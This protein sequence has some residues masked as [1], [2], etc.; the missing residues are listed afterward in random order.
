MSRMRTERC[1][2]SASWSLKRRRKKFFRALR[3]QIATSRLCTPPSAV[4]CVCANRTPLSKFLDPP[5]ERRYKATCHT[6]L[7]SVEWLLYTTSV[8]C[9]VG[10]TIRKTTWPQLPNCQT[11]CHFSCARA[12]HHRRPL[13]A[14]GCPQPTPCLYLQVIRPS[15]VFSDVIYAQWWEICPTTAE[16]L[17]RRTRFF[18]S[19]GSSTRS[20]TFIAHAHYSC[21]SVYLISWTVYLRILCTRHYDVMVGCWYTG[22]GKKGDLRLAIW[23]LWPRAQ[24]FF[25]MKNMPAS[26]RF[27][28]TQSWEGPGNE[29]RREWV[30]HI[31]ELD[32]HNYR[33]RTCNGSNFKTPASLIVLINIYNMFCTVATCSVLYVAQGE[34]VFTPTTISQ[35][36]C[37]G[38]ALLI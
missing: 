28:A 1:Y 31:R 16:L 14:R 30:I 33:S 2:E 22:Q 21:T 17:G 29:A 5:L 7:V 15:Q 24:N 27:S 35:A 9:V 37:S 10:W 11:Q 26:P 38:E 6:Y 13:G 18:H 25:V 12:L 19:L 8:E 3:G 23:Q 34:P 20:S 4:R 36:N 32:D